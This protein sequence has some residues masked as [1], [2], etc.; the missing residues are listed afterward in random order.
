[1]KKVIVASTNP[2]KIRAVERGFKKVFKREKFVVTGVQVLSLVA[3]QPMTDEETLQG[4]T[5]R[6]QGAKKE[7]PNADF[8]IGI[9]GGIEPVGKKDMLCIAWIVILSKS[10]TLG[11]ARTSAFFMPHEIVKLVKKGKELGEADDIVFNRTGSKYTDGTVGALTNGLINRTSYYEEVVILAL[12]PFI[13]S[14][15]T[16][17]NE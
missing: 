10:G 14:H 15:L 4:A 13:N 6:A 12:I 11:K 9:E 17:S 2:V 7:C 5:N 1:M 3:D 8:W 16:F